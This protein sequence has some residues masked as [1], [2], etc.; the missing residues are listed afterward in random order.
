MVMYKFLIPLVVMFARNTKYVPHKPLI[1][2]ELT[3]I[4]PLER[5]RY[6]KISIRKHGWILL[7]TVCLCKV[8][9]NLGTSQRCDIQHLGKGINQHNYG[10]DES[11]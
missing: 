3:V 8:L 9:G 5:H 4:I 7:R 6:L 2:F 10:T 1:V 11:H